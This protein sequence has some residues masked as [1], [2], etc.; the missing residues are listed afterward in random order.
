MKACNPSQD[1]IP[2]VIPT[3]GKLGLADD[4]LSDRLLNSQA[5]R[6][7]GEETELDRK[8]KYDPK[9][10]DQPTKLHLKNS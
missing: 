9:H 7:P 3:G 10:L 1:G 2:V 8:K 5:H 4:S 6:T